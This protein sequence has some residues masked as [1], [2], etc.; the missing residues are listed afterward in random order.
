MLTGYQ[1]CHTTSTDCSVDV[2]QASH[3]V[4]MPYEVRCWARSFS[5]S[6]QRRL[7]WDLFVVMYRVFHGNWPEKNWH[8]SAS[9]LHRM[10]YDGAKENLLAAVFTQMDDLTNNERWTVEITWVFKLKNSIFW[11]FYIKY[12][13]NCDFLNQ[14]SNVSNIFLLVTHL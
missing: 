10:L 9:D 11:S 6:N 8:I 3:Q 2:R 14:Q 4:F 12:W 5:S 1:L 13:E 7:D